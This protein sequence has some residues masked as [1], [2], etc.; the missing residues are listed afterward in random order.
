MNSVSKNK[1]NL[2]MVK[3][4]IIDTFKYVI[5]SMHPKE[6]IKRNIYVKNKE[7]VIGGKYKISINKA[8]NIYVVGF[9][10]ASGAM[11]EEV[12]RILGDLISDGV[13]I[14]L[15]GTREKYDVRRIKLVEASHPI[16]SRENIMGAE[17]IVRLLEK[18]GRRDVVIVLISGGGSALMTLPKEKF[19]LEEIAK[20]TEVVMKAG[21]TINE[22]NAVRK[23]LSRVKGGQLLRYAY[24]ARLYALILSDVVG[25]PLDTIASGPTAPDTTTYR[26]A[27]EVLKKYDLVDKVSP[28]IIEYFK[29]GIAGETPETPKPRDGLFR[30]ANNIIIGNNRIALEKAS[31]ILNERGYRV[32]ILSSYIEGEARDVGTVMASIAL[33]INKYNKPFKKPVI[34]LA[35]GETTVKVRGNGVGG[36]NQEFVL[37][38]GIKAKGLENIVIASMGTD[39]IDGNSPAAGAIIDG[40]IIKESLD[41]GI[42]P[43]TYL[44]NNDSFNYFSEIGGS[45]ITG[46]TDTNVNDIIV[47]AVV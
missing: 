40:E 41:K 35:G 20:T 14:I 28:K 33:E 37:S 43:Y 7:I 42:D 24:P 12:E 9:G 29:S 27:Y 17:K 10:K 32:R 23:H 15:K 31:K 39:G 2:A 6:L 46:P 38:A 47:I 3:R 13:V 5:K 4:D 30:K 45:I 25:D 34:L 44:Y 26:D 18:A 36:R 22:L 11:A 1:L 16:P 21:A 19:T 8:N